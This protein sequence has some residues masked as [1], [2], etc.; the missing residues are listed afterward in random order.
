[1]F[2]G[3]DTQS[4]DVRVFKGRG[5]EVCRVKDLIKTKAFKNYF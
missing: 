2:Q 3:V 1:M 5:Q 4:L